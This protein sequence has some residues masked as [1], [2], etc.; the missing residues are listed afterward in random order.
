LKLLVTH[1]DYR[2]C[3]AGSKLVKWGQEKA[4]KEG[5][6]FAMFASP[7]GISLYSKLGFRSVGI[8]HVQVEGEEEFVERPGMVWTPGE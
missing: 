4:A 8:V 1:P 7:M 6:P 5:L 2:G 3:G